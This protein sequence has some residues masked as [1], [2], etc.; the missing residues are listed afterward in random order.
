[1]ADKKQVKQGRGKLWQ[2]LTGDC[3]DCGKRQIPS[4]LHVE[5]ATG[6]P[7]FSPSGCFSENSPHSKGKQM[8]FSGLV[9]PI[10]FLL[11]RLHLNIIVSEQVSHSELCS[12][13][14]LWI[15]N[16]KSRR[17]MS[18]DFLHHTCLLPWGYFLF[19]KIITRWRGCNCICK[20]A[21]FPFPSRAP[22][23]NMRQSFMR[24]EQLDGFQ[25][26]LSH[27]PR[28]A[29]LHHH[30]HNAPQSHPY[31]PQP[32]VSL[33]GQRDSAFSRTSQVMILLHACKTYR[34][35]STQQGILQGQEV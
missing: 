5:P 12:Y 10:G 1:M 32:V 23:L 33:I 19:S 25:N 22:N 35:N 11:W 6:E 16:W 9:M 17:G 34:K 4:I 20:T 24:V 15:F 28:T 18:C 21:K 3:S 30:R 31:W 29:Q 13:F 8:S 7:L 14:L 26:L 2:S 27:M